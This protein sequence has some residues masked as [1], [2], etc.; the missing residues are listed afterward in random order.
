MRGEDIEAEI[1]LALEEAHRG[2]KRTI[3]LQVDDPCPE[4]RGSVD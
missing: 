4:C 2:V 1:S 3:T